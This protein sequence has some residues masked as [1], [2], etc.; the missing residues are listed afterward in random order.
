MARPA[1]SA[2]TAAGRPAAT[3]PRVTWLQRIRDLA[4]VIV[5]FAVAGLALLGYATFR[6]WQVGSQDTRHHA[7]AIVVL[8]AAQYNGRPSPV[9]AARLDHAI[10]LWNQGYAEWFVVTGGKLPGDRYTEA[11]TERRYAV[12][13]GVP[14]KAIL[15][16]T[17]GRTTLE[18]M[19]NVRLLFEKNG[20]HSALFVSDRTH[21]LRV[22][23]LAADQG[24]VAWS[25]PTETSPTDI[26]PNLHF[27]SV[28][29][30]VGAMGLYLLVEQAGANGSSPS[31]APAPVV[32]ATPSI[33]PKAAPGATKARGSAAGGSAAP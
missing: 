19:Q 14:A 25:S 22:L 5:A 15:A 23:R 29:H 3:A 31:V 10:D 33:A 32:S 7:D 16:E 20:L 17:T 26:D 21:M 9:L 8:G 27:D 30:E 28:V 24:I 13:R 11:D 18:S 1:S 4:V 6:V 2:G 12:A